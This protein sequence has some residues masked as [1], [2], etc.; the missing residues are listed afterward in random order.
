VQQLVNFNAVPDY[1]N[2]LVYILNGLKDEN[3][4]V[5][6]MAGLVR[7]RVTGEARVA[8][9]ASAA[10]RLKAR[11]QRTSIGLRRAIGPFRAY[12]VT[13]V[14]KNNVK[15]RW[16]Q[17]PLEVQAYV[18]VG[19]RIATCACQRCARSRCARARAR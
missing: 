6:Q 11:S 15:D 19:V 12:M 9:H 17:L 2:Y 14:L 16:A 1:N 18:K 5:R 3:P 7:A 13:Q 10:L 4:S 8:S